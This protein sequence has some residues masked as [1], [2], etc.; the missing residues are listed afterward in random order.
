MSR[1]SSTTFG[2]GEIVRLALDGRLRVPHFQRSY[3]WDERNITDLFDSIWKGFPIG[4]LLLWERAEPAGRLTFGSVSVD[5]AQ[6]DRALVVVDGQQRLTTLVAS[7]G[8]ASVPPDPRFEV[9]FD[10]RAGRFTHAHHRVVP[11]FW[12][13][14]RVALESRTL[15]NWLSSHQDAL[16]PGDV[17]LADTMA[18]SLR[19]YKVPAYVIEQDDEQLLREVFDRTNS[20]GKPIKRAQVFHALFGGGTESASAAAV[21]DDLRH[22]GF[23]DLDEQRIIQSVLAIRGGDVGRDLHGEFAPNEDPTT[24]YDQTSEALSRVVRFLQALGVP[25]VEMLPSAFPVPVLASFYYLHPE[26]SMYA[27]ALLARWIWRGWAHGYGRAGQTPALRQA[28]RSV[29][30]VKLDPASAPGEAQAVMAL[31]ADISD[32]PPP[33]ALVGFNSS[34]SASRLALLAIAAFGPKGPDGDLL[35]LPALF[36]TH[37]SR[38]V[39]VLAGGPASDLGLRA[40]WD[41]SA[42]GL[43][44]AEDQQ[45]L[46][47]HV[48]DREAAAAL[49]AKDIPKLAAHRGAAVKALVEKFLV[50]KL[51]PG[52]PVVPPLDELWVPDP[53]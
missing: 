17:D 6:T 12:L 8:P 51:E 42:P 26:A 37:G 36:A 49:R 38:V 22:L 44:G 48:I 23:G 50:Q 2:P 3:V 33:V 16:E 21:V 43:S 25:H 46:A 40:L 53:A 19:D 11:E 39:S 14:V 4:T 24:W 52:L 1:T 47:S 28:V 45:V 34:S 15:L 32:Q 27:E 35:D 9:W 5:A 41:P 30:P 31:L 29:N 18:G 7:L 20:A 13:P 10:L